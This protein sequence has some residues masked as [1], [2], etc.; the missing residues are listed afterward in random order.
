MKRHFPTFDAF[1]D[2]VSK[3]PVGGYQ[4]IDRYPNEDCW[5]GTRTFDDALNLAE[6]GW[7]DGLARMQTLRGKIKVP[8]SQTEAFVTRFVEAGDEP[9]IGRYLENQPD[10]MLEFERQFIPGT[11]RIVKILLNAF[12]SCGV[13]HKAIFQRGAAAFALADAI[14][15]SGL[16]CEISLVL[17]TISRSGNGEMS[18]VLIPLKAADQH[19]EP[20]RMAFMLAHPSI[21]RRFMGKLYDQES[22]SEFQK[23]W[24]S[25]GMPGD[26]TDVPADTVYFGALSLSECST[27]EKATEFI[28]RMLAKYTEAA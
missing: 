5:H 19:V 14:E 9:D 27:E 13:D 23:H 18:D 26:L 28:N 17:A 20:D 25:W 11:G 22:E 10:S 2:G 6:R 24:S 1:I 7:P 21:F 3:P 15:Q 4:S 8:Q 16:R 12:I